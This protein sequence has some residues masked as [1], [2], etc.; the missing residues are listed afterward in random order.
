M[1]LD[2]LTHAEAIEKL[3]VAEAAVSVLVEGIHHSCDLEVCQRAAEQLVHG[4]HSN[5]AHAK[6]NT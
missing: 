3:L 2:S 5:A 1:R 6:S 4:L